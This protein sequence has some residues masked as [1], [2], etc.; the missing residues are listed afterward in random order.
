M[1]DS[2]KCI[3]A[4]AK[5]GLPPND[6]DYVC[7]SH[8]HFDDTGDP[9]AIKKSTFLVG[10]GCRALFDDGYPK[11]AASP[12]P[13]DLLPADRTHYLPVADWAPLGPSSRAFDFFGDGTLYTVDS[14]CHVEGHI[15]ILARTSPDGAWIYLAGDSVDHWR[16][17]EGLS[18]IKTGMPYGPTFCIHKDKRAAEESIKRIQGLRKLPRVQLL[19]THGGPWYD[20]NKGGDAF[21]PGR[22]LP[23]GEGGNI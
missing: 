6:I 22:I 23:V 12:L 1:L 18:E 10:D 5:G 9:H 3:D 14:P 11:N 15:N 4:L 2:P 16:I 20:I 7:L 17:L 21:W 13:G 8:I 19:L